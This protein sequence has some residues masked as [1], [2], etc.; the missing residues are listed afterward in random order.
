MFS[1]LGLTI[2]C[3]DTGQNGGAF[4]VPRVN[5]KAGLQPVTGSSDAVERQQP[6]TQDD[7]ATQLARASVPHPPAEKRAPTKATAR[8]GF[9]LQKVRGER[10]TSLTETGVGNKAEGT[11]RAAEAS[12][13]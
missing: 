4:W 9:R 12:V 7:E 11:P 5:S 2:G 10:S 8:S 1:W 13:I 3:C 6:H